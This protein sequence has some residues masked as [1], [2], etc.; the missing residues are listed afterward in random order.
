MNVQ[1][2]V[3]YVNLFYVIFDTI[4]K[5]PLSLEKQKERKEKEN[6]FNYSVLR[7]ILRK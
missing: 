6:Y 2:W 5:D 4:A 1:I 7:C 3:I